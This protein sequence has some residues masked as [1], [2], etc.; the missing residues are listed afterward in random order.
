MPLNTGYAGCTSRFCD[1]FC[2]CF[3]NIPI[4]RA[5]DDVI[6]GQ[7]V[8]GYKRR[9]CFRCSNLHLIVNVA[10]TYVQSATEN[11]RE[12]QDVVDLVREVAASSTHHSSASQIL[13]AV[14]LLF[15]RIVDPGLPVRRVTVTANRV[16]SDA[17]TQFD[18]FSDPAKQEKEKRLQRT[19][20]EIKKKYGKNA[21]LKGT[22]LQ[23]GATTIERNGQIGGHRA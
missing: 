21:I 3:A 9:D 15:D 14:L 6:R 2:N 10:R 8:V 12:S 19:M 4:Q 5:G 17:Y 7:L 16:V 1:C 11:A 13:P 23:E 22:S 18:L 20:L